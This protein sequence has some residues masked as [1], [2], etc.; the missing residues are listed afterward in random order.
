M[1]CAIPKRE[2]LYSSRI[3]PF[4]YSTSLYS[5]IFVH[6]SS[7]RKSVMHVYDKQLYKEFLSKDGA[8]F[9]INYTDTADFVLSPCTHAIYLSWPKS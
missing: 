9:L 2:L 1:H 3:L 5:S 8:V 7:C 6:D 4:T